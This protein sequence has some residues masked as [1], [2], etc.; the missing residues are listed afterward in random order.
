MK[1]RR[2]RDAEPQSLNSRGSRAQSSEQRDPLLPPQ[3]RCSGLRVFASSLLR[4]RVTTPAAPV[5]NPCHSLLPSYS[6]LRRVKKLFR[7]KASNFARHP[8]CP[9]RSL[10]EQSQRGGLKQVDASTAGIIPGDRG[11]A[12]GSWFRLPLQSAIA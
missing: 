5:N 10:I 11:K 4:S 9:S 1:Q 6:P 12:G 3:S 2:G 7:T 8:H